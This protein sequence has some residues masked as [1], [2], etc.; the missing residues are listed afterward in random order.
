VASA[1]LARRFA[2]LK[3]GDLRV[4]DPRAPGKAPRQWL[5]L[6]PRGHPAVA[7]VW[8]NTLAWVRY[9]GLR[10]GAFLI[11]MAATA[12]ILLSL[13]PAG[14]REDRR[15]LALL[16]VMPLF[17]TF[18]MSVVLGPRT[19]RNDLRQDLT[20]LPLL[21]TYP[22]PSAQIMLAEMASPAL[23]LTVFQMAVLATTLVT[24]PAVLR[25]GVRVVPVTL[26]LVLA[27]PVLGVLN[28]ASMAIQNATVMLFPGWVRLGPGDAGLEAIGQN[29][30]V[31]IGQ[32]LVLVVG[33]LPAILVASVVYFLVN[34][35]GTTIALV[36]AVLSGSLVLLVGVVLMALALGSAF[37]RTEPSAVV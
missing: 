10:S 27:V 14:S 11:A 20:S 33:L 22:L 31:T 6:A 2:A 23:A 1:E 24:M 35:L 9:G 30:L 19:L 29:V 8:K 36:A 21:K 18:G 7:I 16:S 5:P 34:P 25:D 17:M 32:L 15:A 12:T 28:A 4:P 3:R 26:L 37:E 13:L